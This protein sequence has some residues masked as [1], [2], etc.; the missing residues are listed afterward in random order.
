M[1]QPLYTIY[2]TDQRSWWYDFDSAVNPDYALNYYSIYSDDSYAN[3]ID[4]AAQGTLQLNTNG[5]YQNLTEAWNCVAACLDPPEVTT[6]FWTTDYAMST[7]QNCMVLPII[8]ALLAGGNLT[9]TAVNV[10]R[11]FHIRPDADLYKNATV[12]WPVINNCINEFCAHASNRETAPG[13]NETGSIPFVW[14]TNASESVQGSTTQSQNFTLPANTINYKLCDRLKAYVNPDIG[15]IGVFIAYVMQMAIVLSGWLLYHWNDT[16][17]VWPETLVLLMFRKHYDRKKAW[18]TALRH[19]EDRRTSKH[20]AAIVSALAEFLNTQV[21]FM[22]AVQIAAIIAITN[23][24]A[25]DAT[26]WQAVW[27]NFGLFYN[28]AFAGC[29]PVIFTLLVLRLDGRLNGRQA[30]YPI[31]MTIVCVILSSVVWFQ[32]W[33]VANAKATIVNYSGPLLPSCGAGVAPIKY[34]YSVDWFYRNA[35]SS[36][37]RAIPMFIFCYV[38][39]ICILIEHVRVFDFEVQ[40]PG[41]ETMVHGHVFDWVRRKL[42]GHAPT[43]AFLRRRSTGNGNLARSMRSLSMDTKESLW[44]RVIA[45]TVWA[46]VFLEYLWIWNFGPEEG[47]K[48]K[49]S[50]SRQVSNVSELD[51]LVLPPQYGN[52]ATVSEISVVPP[53]G[54]F[55]PL[56][57]KQ[58][59]V[60]VYEVRRGPYQSRVEEASGSADRRNGFLRTTSWGP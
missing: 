44:D 30:L 43:R 51:Q 39:I 9:Q 28:I 40:A 52:A 42:V 38:V 6:P 32:T 23:P 22:I 4:G 1:A 27:N 2:E 29:F 50:T 46:P 36:L 19:Q 14:M 31:G 5:C 47:F 10:A 3:V 55:E 15:G 12:G 25:L 58:V 53:R 60:E 57:R 13:C 54:T 18:D 20:C 35:T 17:S 41:E 16:W 33:F 37:S 48:Y 34:C 49:A 26:S 24:T 56:S 59:D 45:V 7:L 11:K 21:F 8:A